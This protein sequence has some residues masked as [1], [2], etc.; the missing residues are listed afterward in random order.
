MLPELQRSP[1]EELCLVARVMDPS[2]NQSVA[3]FLAKALEPPAPQ[4]VTAGITLL[5]EIGAMDAEER[6]TNLGCHLARLPLPPSIGKLLLYGLMFR[7]LSPIIT[8]ACALGYRYATAR[9]A[10]CVEAAAW[11]GCMPLR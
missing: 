6:L 7:C 2:L 3:Q 9:V 10:P 1:L 8:V 11:S 4:A 5:Q